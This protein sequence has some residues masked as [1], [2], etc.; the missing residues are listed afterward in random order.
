MMNMNEIEGRYVQVYDDQITRLKPEGIA[1][2]VS[3]L[4]DVHTHCVCDVPEDRWC[5]VHFGEDERGASVHRCVR[6][7]DVLPHKA[8]T[9]NRST[10]AYVLK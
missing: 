2:V 5:L 10:R 6:T 1:K 8:V 7:T 3:V 9:K 4:G